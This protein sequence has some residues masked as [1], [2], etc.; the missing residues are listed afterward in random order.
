MSTAFFAFW[1]GGLTATFAVAFTEY[2]RMGR[3]HPKMTLYSV[4]WKRILPVAIAAFVFWPAL[5]V[6][7]YLQARLEANQME[8][9][10]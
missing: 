6:A 9:I 2:V 7:L 8:K 10:R 1:L 5:L 4:Y 3:D